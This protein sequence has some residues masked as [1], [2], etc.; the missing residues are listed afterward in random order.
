MHYVG[1]RM[2]KKNDSCECLNCIDPHDG[3]SSSPLLYIQY[4]N[5][6][7]QEEGK[8]TVFPSSLPTFALE[9][10]KV[11]LEL[12]DDISVGNLVSLMM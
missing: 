4:S 10:E 12:D 5:T 7:G 9:R 1:T 6:V 3:A 8:H 2:K 11:A